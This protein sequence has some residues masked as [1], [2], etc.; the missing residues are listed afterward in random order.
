MVGID[1]RASGERSLALRDAYAAERIAAAARAEDRPRVLVLMGQYHVAPCH[2]PAQVERALGAAHARERWSSTRTARASTGRWPARA[3]RARWRRW[4]CAEGEL[5][6]LNTS[7][8]VCQ[9]SF[10]DYLEAEAGDAPLR[11]ARARSA[12]GRWRG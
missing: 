7:P 12:S 4:R 9:Q 10:L 6:L 8:V 3:A 11:A 2:L 1:R 5:C